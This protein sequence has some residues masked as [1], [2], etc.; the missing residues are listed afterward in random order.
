[1]VINSVWYMCCGISYFECSVLVVWLNFLLFQNDFDRM[2]N[3]LSSERRG[4]TRP[5]DYDVSSYCVI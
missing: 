3:H 4:V 5:R 1:M 2:N